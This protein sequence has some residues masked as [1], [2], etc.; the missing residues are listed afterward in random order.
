MAKEFAQIQWDELVEDECRRL[1]RAAVLEDLDRGQDWTTVALVPMEVTGRAKVVAAA[2]GR[3][4]RHSGGKGRDRRDGSPHPPGAADFGR[5]V[6]RCGSVIAILE[7]PARSLLTIERTD[8]E[9]R[10]PAFGHRHADA[11][12]CGSDRG[13]K[14]G[15]TILAKLRPAGGDWKNMPFGKGADITI[16]RDCST[17]C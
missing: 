6:G 16:A 2:G 7:G 1:V 10:R 14:A 5:A 15:C 11:A 3:A 12:V 4:R 8:A 17:R 9:L 13:T